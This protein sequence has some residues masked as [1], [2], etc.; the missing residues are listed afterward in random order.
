ME[1]FEIVKGQVDI[2]TVVEH[3]GVQI[4]SNGKG[5]CP[6]HK[7]KTPSFSIDKNNNYF[8][9]FGCGV[10]VEEVKTVIQGLSKE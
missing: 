1:I 2:Q 7:E 6:F 4:N 5:L 8:K 10:S 3:F 9:C